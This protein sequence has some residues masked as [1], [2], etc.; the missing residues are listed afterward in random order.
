MDFHRIVRE[1][2]DLNERTEE[3]VVGSRKI[4]R[5]ELLALIY[6]MFRVM[7]LLVGHVVRTANKEKE[8]M[9]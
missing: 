1:L 7:D 4:P 6:E 2:D 3:L 8:E 9:R 5:D